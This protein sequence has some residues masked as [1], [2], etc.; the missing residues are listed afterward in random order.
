MINERWKI[1]AKRLLWG[2]YRIESAYTNRGKSNRVSKLFTR[3][4][5]Q[6][7]KLSY[8]KPINKNKYVRIKAI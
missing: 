2:K 7:V 8:N 1:K 6:V 3:R 5:R 4:I